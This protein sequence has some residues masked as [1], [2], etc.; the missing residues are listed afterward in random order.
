MTIKDIARNTGVSVSTVSRVLNHHPDVS[1]DVRQRV[2]DEVE[3]SGYVPN[4]IAR[5]LVR[6][7]S[8]TIGVIVR[9]NENLFFS[10]VLK[11]IGSEIAD[12]GY[13]MVLHYIDSDDDE[14]KAGAILERERK[15]LGLIFLGGRFDYSP[16]DVAGINIPYVLCTYNNCFGSLEDGDFS[17]VTVD[18]H[19]IAYTATRELTRRG[20]R[21]IAAVIPSRND[22]S[23]SELRYNGF[24]DALRDSQLACQPELVEETGGCFQMADAYNG[25]CRLL[26]R[27][28]DFTAL[29]TLSDTSGMA[30]MKALS[31]AGLR[32]PEDVSVISID[33]LDV[34]AY[35]VPTLSTMVQPSA[36]LGKESVRILAKMI[37]NH[38]YTRHKLLEAT[39]REG[40]SIRTLA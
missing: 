10:S 24:L 11:V 4:N 33:G 2:L 15:L 1:D 38:D 26:E 5:D 39:L 18:D 20:H 17:S 22:H 34:S 37:K 25:V 32:I 21:R 40:S 31:D 13:T 7:H 3:R 29:L 36:D 12:H 35:T 14:V 27:T 19:A 23:I 30:A 16:E 6:N 8:D 28:R 9:G